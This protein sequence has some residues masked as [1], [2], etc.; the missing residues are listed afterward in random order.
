MIIEHINPGTQPV[1]E[2][3]PLSLKQYD[4]KIE[5]IQ[6]YPEV[7]Q[8]HVD[9]WAS[10]NMEAD[11]SRQ[12]EAE[13]TTNFEH[14]PSSTAETENIN[15]SRDDEWDGRDGPSSPYQSHSIEVVLESEEPPRGEKSCRLCGESFVKDSDLVRHVAKSHK[16]HKAFK[17]LECNK[18]FE[19]R[20]YL[21]LHTKVHTGEKPFRCDFCDKSFTQNSTRVVH[22]RVH[23]GEKPYFCSRCGKSFATSNH[24]KYCKMQIE[25]KT[26]PEKRNVDEDHREEKAFKCPE[27]NK[28]FKQKHHLALHTRVHTGEKP[29]SCDICGKSFSQNSGRTVH[30]RTHTGEKPYLCK[31]CGKRFTHLKHSKICTGIQKKGKNKTFRCKT[32][33]R[34]FYTD[35]DL[36]VHMEVHESW[37]RHIEKSQE[38]A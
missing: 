7:K 30:M 37:K 28:E 17:C 10:S 35:S 11:S 22:M 18:E 14:L 5:E 26:T 16:Q 8:E 12:L 29:F 21:I 34:T 1:S 19:Q 2:E 38:Q 20:W 6:E 13:Q 3:L 15:N 27:C 9:Q 31:K 36:E 33:G 24:F 32:C 25:S 23:T 4:L